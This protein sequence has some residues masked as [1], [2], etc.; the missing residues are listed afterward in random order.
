LIKS[1]EELDD[2]KRRRKALIVVF[3]ADWSLESKRLV[4]E[5]AELAAMYEIDVEEVDIEIVPEVVEREKIIY[6]P[7]VKLYINGETKFVHEGS[8]GATLTDKE[9]IRRG[10]KDILKKYGLLK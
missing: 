1:L 5:I 7:T 8:T 9:H 2:K 4:K 6:V 10:I 3:T